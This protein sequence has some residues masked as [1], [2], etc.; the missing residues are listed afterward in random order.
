MNKDIVTNIGDDD[1][2]PNN[3]G[4]SVSV[5][6]AFVTYATYPGSTEYFI[7]VWGQA[8]AGI[9]NKRVQDVDGTVH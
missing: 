7:S 6:G 1:G 5:I 4:A 2:T 3:V 8:L 9:D